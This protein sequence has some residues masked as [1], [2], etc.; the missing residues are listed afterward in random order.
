[1]GAIIALAASCSQSPAGCGD[2]CNGRWSEEK[3][4]EWYSKLP[5][6]SGCDYIPA[7]AINQIEMWS[8]DTFDEKQIDKEMTWAE[9][10]GFKTM[11]VYLSSVVYAND[12]EGFKKRIDTFLGICKNHGIRPLFVFFDD[13]WNEE[14]KYGKQPEPQKGIHNSGWV[15]DP[16]VS[17]RKDTV[18]LYPELEKY[19]TDIISTF[20]NDDR[21]LLWDLYNEPGNKGHGVSSLPLLKKV[22]AWARSAK[23]S[24]PVTSGIWNVEN[25]FAPLNAF[26][27]ENSDVISYH[28]YNDVKDHSE[29]IRYL[30]MLNRPLICTEYMARRN[31]STFQTVMPL[32]KKENVVAINWGF[33]AGKTNT[34]FAWDTPLPDVDEP[35]LWFHDIYRQD[36]TP[37]AQ[38]EVDTIK[39]LNGV[40]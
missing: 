31:G 36:K 4:N 16:S 15:Q 25:S 33:V 23:P 1:M 10:L 34:I 7:N 19:V 30:K 13:C 21:I 37:F 24:Q 9:E 27:L 38:A 8:A 3:A 28:N 35:E 6:L 11:R 40:K 12:A 18:K 22:F 29:Q 17:L 32:L 2:Q 14:A 26:A 39:K 20:A 5:W